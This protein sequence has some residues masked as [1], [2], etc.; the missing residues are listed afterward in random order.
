VRI[1]TLSKLTGAPV[2]TIKFYLREELIPPG[3]PSGRNQ[4]EYGDD[5]LRRIQL[6]RALTKVGRLEL[7]SVHRLLDVIDEDQGTLSDL[8]TRANR[9]ICP[10]EPEPLD[11][12]VTKQARED[13]A[14]LVG[15]LGWAADPDGPGYSRFLTI[16]ITMRELGCEYGIDYF[17]PYAESAKRLMAQELDLLPDEVVGADRSTAVVRTILLG[18]A[19]TA[20]GSM[21][22]D[23]LLAQRAG[24]ARRP[25]SDA[26]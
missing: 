20:L 2:A 22:Q 23:H 9:A 6:I 15:R 10:V 7:S 14:D 24:H 19:M 16:L 17:A 3:T 21:A 8:Y 5:H 13:V 18:I 1:S 12:P 11:T 26:A 25:D 4:A